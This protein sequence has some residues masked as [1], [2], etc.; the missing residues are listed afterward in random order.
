MFIE[1]EERNRK[2]AMQIIMT[3]A[4]YGEVYNNEFK[5]FCKQIRAHKKQNPRCKD[6]Y[7]AVENLHQSHIPWL[8]LMKYVRVIQPKNQ[9]T[10]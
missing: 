7:H 6:P 5:R 3:Q 10:K 8:M 2:T 1:N 9:T 4:E